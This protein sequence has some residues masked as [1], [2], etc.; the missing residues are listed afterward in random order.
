M[1]TDCIPHARSLT[2]LLFT[3]AQKELVCEAALMSC[4]VALFHSSCTW[5]SGELRNHFG[6][7]LTVTKIPELV[8]CRTI[9]CLS[10]RP[11][12]RGQLNS[13]R[14]YRDDLLD[15]FGSAKTYAAHRVKARSRVSVL[16]FTV[17]RGQ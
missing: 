11:A 14:A 7:E 16:Q 4:N 9:W 10:G 13:R 17:G 8:E 1:D 15:R 3:V 12:E 2:G 6:S 5:C